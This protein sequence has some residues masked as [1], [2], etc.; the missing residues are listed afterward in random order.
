MLRTERGM[1]LIGAAPR[2]PYER[3]ILRLAFLAPDIQRAI[4]EG[5]QPHHLNLET[6]KKVQIP[7]AWSDQRERLGFGQRPTLC[8]GEQIA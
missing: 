2:S 3:S 1:P 8:S 5:R 4:L 6:L 7:L